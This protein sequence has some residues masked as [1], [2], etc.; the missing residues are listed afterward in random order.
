MQTVVVHEVAE[1]EIVYP[2]FRRIGG[3]DQIAQERIAEQ[4]EAEELLAK[5]EHMDATSAEFK[6]SLAKLHKAALDHA[7]REETEVFPRLIDSLDAHELEQLGAA[8]EMAKKVAPT[9]P[10][11]HAPNSPPGNLLVGPVLALVD[12][13]RDAA[14]SALDRARS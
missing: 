3:T 11:P 14:Q 8:Y 7:K 12:R 9:H 10:H 13:V 1:E 4:Q 6:Q 2:A 5:M